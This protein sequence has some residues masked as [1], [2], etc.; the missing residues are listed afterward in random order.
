MPTTARI[1][2]LYLILGVLILVSVVPLW[3][4]GTTVVN[5]ESDRLKTNEKLLQN[6][7]TRSLSDDIAQRQANLVSMMGNLA[8]AVQVASSNDLSGTHLASPELRAILEKF[9]SS[10]DN[11][12]YATLVNSESKGISAGRNFLLD[13]FMRR[14]LEH[15][16]AAA[17]DGRAY[18]GPAMQAGGGK[19]SRIVR[20]ISV[21]VSSDGKFMG[22]IG[23][24]VDLQFLINRLHEQSRG[25]LLIYV[26]DRQGRLVAGGDN[27]HVTG[28]D[29]REYEIVQNFIDQGPKARFV[30]TR[31]FKVRQNNESINLLGTYSPVPT[32]DWAVVAQKPQ[33]DAYQGVYEMQRTA[34]WLAAVAV[35]V[36]I[37]IS[38]FAARAISDP[39]KTLTESSRAIAK[40]DFSQRVHLT[41]RTEIGELAATFNTMSGDLERLVFDL[42]RSAQEN[43]ALFLSSIQ[44][45]AGAV[46]EKDPYTKG[47]SDRVT[48]YSVILA[49]ELQLLKEE[50]EKIRI[51][52]QLH[53]VG[54]IGIED[55]ILKKPGA[56]TPEE[57][58]IMKTHTSKG[59]SILRPVQALREM[60]P[61]IEGHHESL[62]GRGY[63]HGYKGDQISLMPRIIMVADTFDAM[64]TNRP[65]QAAMDPEYVVRIVNSLVNTKFD[66]RVVAALST[67]FE[68][69]S[70]RIHRAAAVTEGQVAAA[71]AAGQAQSPSAPQPAASQPATQSI[72]ADQPATQNAGEPHGD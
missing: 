20:L 24:I 15:A 69:G 22:M 54:K 61:G 44:M 27:A 25:N 63:P 51:S 34:K 57:F 56:L 16:F 31:E 33:R 66:P 40:G 64:T 35:F 47:H 30:A 50:I 36:S 3:F 7:I 48:R 21:P 67:V 5:D 1:P 13:D 41:S 32:L 72:S 38:I 43:H 46:D 49:T 28:Q 68:R 9:V 37:L 18:N 52:A 2:I 45:L 14:E 23:V 53:D 26:V 55:R 70:F 39:V 6:T 4:Y 10:S 60:I 65:Y 11:V 17:T 12:S 58:E 42:K 8:S 19:D 59:A 29:M 62:D 71:A